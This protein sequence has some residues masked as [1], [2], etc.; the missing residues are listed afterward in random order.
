MTESLLLAD[1]RQLADAHRLGHDAERVSE[2]VLLHQANAEI[3]ESLTPAA[4]AD[5]KSAFA[6]LR[7]K[8]EREGDRQDK[9]DELYNGQPPPAEAEQEPVQE[10]EQKP[11][12]K[13]SGGR[14]RAR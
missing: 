8:A 13:R 1:R 9:S 2:A 6:E 14:S 5:T 3:D 11:E 12:R 4:A 10:H 7:N